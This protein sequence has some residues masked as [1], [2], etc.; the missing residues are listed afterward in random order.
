[1]A[2]LL[3]SM[4]APLPATGIFLIQPQA[5]I[6]HNSEIVL[7]RTKALLPAR[8]AIASEHKV[9]RGTHRFASS[10]YII[11]RIWQYTYL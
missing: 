8:V 7:P 4:I 3:T 1:M 10:L 11:V 5:K 6:R 2:T 9:T